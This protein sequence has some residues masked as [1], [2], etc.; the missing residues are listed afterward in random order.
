MAMKLLLL[1]L[2][3]LASAR[4]FLQTE[5]KLE[6]IRNRQ[7]PVF[8]TQLKGDSLTE[9]VNKQQ[10]FWKAAKPEVSRRRS[11]M[12]VK[13]TKHPEDVQIPVASLRPEHLAAIPD[14]FDART[15]WPK[16]AASIGFIRDQADCGSC[17]AFAA[18]EAMSDRFCIAS[19]GA[20]V[21]TLSADDMLSCCG[22]F[23]GYGCEGGYPI[24]AWNW[25]VKDGVVTGSGYF[26]KAGCKPYPIEPCGTHSYNGSVYK[27]PCAGEEKT[28]KC[29]KSCVDG[30][31]GDYAS[32][33]H[34]GKSAYAVP[35]SVEAIQ[36]EIMT[37]GPVEAA[38]TVYEDF[39][40]YKG[41]VYVHTAGGVLGGHAVKILGWGVD[42]GTPYWLVA[43]SWNVEWG[44]N[45]F[46]RIV[47]GTNECGLEE[48][49]VG[50]VPKV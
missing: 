16:C 5:S 44:E 37:N 13:Y 39:E 9:Y 2:V 41:G 30:Y 48:A 20:D 35:Q 19:D 4:T 33:K 10:N 23:C 32:D 25:W 21:Y 12:S 24:R 46:F 38:F 42:N 40:Q 43:N 1:A 22:R 29:I 27:H 11:L 6:S 3:G 15:Q 26:E 45:G 28:P 31:S 18:A 49:V 17:W 47:R 34:Y 14:S 50:G 8:A 7:I 36:N